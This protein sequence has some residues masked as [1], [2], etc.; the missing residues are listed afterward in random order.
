MPVLLWRMDRVRRKNPEIK[1]NNKN[2]K[3]YVILL[4]ILSARR[5]LVLSIIQEEHKS[6]C[7]LSESKSIQLVPNRPRHH[8]RL[9]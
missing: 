1:I 2:T 8:L 4:V 3:C 6:W 5:R 9:L 7:T